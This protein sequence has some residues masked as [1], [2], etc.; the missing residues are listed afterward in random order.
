MEGYR[1]GLQRRVT[2][3]NTNFLENV[4]FSIIYCE[5]T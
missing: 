2:V 4:F 5:K 3:H 1:G